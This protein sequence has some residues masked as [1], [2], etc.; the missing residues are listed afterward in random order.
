MPLASA[1]W[2]KLMGVVVP[3]VPVPPVPPVPVPPPAGGVVAVPPV[4]LAMFGVAVTGMLPWAR[5]W[6]EVAV[7]TVVAVPT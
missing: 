5:P 2:L 3:P 1:V 7:D 4:P 6:T